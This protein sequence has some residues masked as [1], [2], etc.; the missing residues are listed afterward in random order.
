MIRE[1]IKEY[2]EKTA[3]VAEYYR[4]FNKVVIVKGEG[5]I[6]EIFEKL[7]KEIDNRIYSDEQL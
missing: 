5:T 1:R 6:V 2:H 3:I 4:K 7:C